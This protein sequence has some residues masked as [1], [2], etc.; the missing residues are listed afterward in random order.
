MAKTKKSTKKRAASKKKTKIKKN[1][2][3]ASGEMDIRKGGRWDE[4]LDLETTLE[5]KLLED[6]ILSAKLAIQ[7][8]EAETRTMPF[9]RR[10]GLRLKDKA[11]KTE[12]AFNRLRALRKGELLPLQPDD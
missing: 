5:E 6:A 7:E 12:R 9:E 1:S 4:A 10:G 3:P 2:K 11:L 8:L